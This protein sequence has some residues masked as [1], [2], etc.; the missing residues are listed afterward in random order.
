MPLLFL[1]PLPRRARKGDVLAQ[2]LHSGALSKA[3]VGK[4]EL[5]GA[6]AVVEIPEGAESKAVRILD[7]W[8]WDER[9]VRAWI[10]STSSGTTS[11]EDHFQRLAR[12]LELE[13]RAQAQRVR[14]NIRAVSPARAERSGYSLV[15]LVI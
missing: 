5:R 7:G 12:L 2:L 15:D 1:E 6:Q 11:S 14:E 3:Q 10:G 4:I 8:T 9:K 13:S